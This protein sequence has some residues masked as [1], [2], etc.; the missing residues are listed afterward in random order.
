MIP[1]TKPTLPT[2][3]RYVSYL[4]RIWQ[5]KWLTNNG[6]LSLLLEQRLR[7]YLGVKNMVLVSNGTLAL[8]LA[9]KSLGL[10]GEV[11]TTPFTFV[12]TTN[13]IVWEGLTP[14]FADID[15]ETFNINPEDVENKITERTCAIL[16]VHVYGNPCDV[17]SLATIAGD[18]GLKL[19][20]DGAHSFSV[21][22][23]N[24]SVFDYGDVTTLSFHATKVYNTIEGGALVTHEEKLAE[25]LRLLRDHGIISAEEFIGLGINAKMNEF[26]AAMGLCNLELVNQDIEMRKTLYKLYV[27]ELSN[28]GKLTFQRLIGS[29]YNYAY[30]PVCFEDE[31]QRNMVCGELSRRGFG[32]RKYFYPL[33]VSAHYFTAK[34]NLIDKFGLNIASDVARRI[35][36]L[37]LYPSLRLDDVYRIVNIIKE[38]IT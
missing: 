3:E 2:L 28:F 7:D 1:V 13:S 32:S 6:D 21:E 38:T 16:A 15:A 11:I 36:C 25:E 14:I 9:L 33:T 8:N 22:Y 20:Y 17:E 18:Y 30:M 26:Q 35:L 19:I 29:K 24:R 37:P 10:Q 31:R 5:T 12:A 23:A 34:Q 27:S 4:K